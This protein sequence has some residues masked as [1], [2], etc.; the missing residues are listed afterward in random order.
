MQVGA[1]P[2]HIGMVQH[3]QVLRCHVQPLLR[4]AVVEFETSPGEM[5]MLFE[6]RDCLRAPFLVCP[7]EFLLRVDGGEIIDERHDEVGPEPCLV[8]T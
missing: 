4:L 7:I 2:L 8:D 5:D 1:N 3:C 6:L